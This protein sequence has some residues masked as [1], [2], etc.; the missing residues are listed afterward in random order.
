MRASLVI[1][2]LLLVP[3]KA[4]PA[5]ADYASLIPALQAHEARLLTIGWRLARGNAALC[6]SSQPA[7][8]A[9]LTDIRDFNRPGDAQAAMRLKGN[10][11]VA[12][13]ATGS[14]AQAAGLRAGEELIA[15]DGMAI[16]AKLQAYARIEEG[17]A[18]RGTVSL[19]VA[20]PGAAARNVAIRGEAACKV[21]FELLAG[22]KIAKS[23]ATGVQVG[24]ELLAEHPSDDVAATMVA[25]EMAHVLLV[26]L[27]RLDAGTRNYVTIRRTEREADGLA[28]W[29]M[30]NAGYDPAAAPRFMAAWGPRHSGGAMRRPNHDSWQDREALMRAQVA[31][32]AAARL[33]RPR[34]PLDWRN[35]FPGQDGRPAR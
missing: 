25:H 29:L 1:A 7:I 21:R 11:A 5:Q 6:R 19:T 28:P 35:D 14:P 10:V 18:R 8:G 26:H 30:A 12:A 4:F 34:S 24:V 22:S 17:L 31:R 20:A 27:A 13:V 33:A 2:L 16:S 23:D 15:V 32:I 3:A 9:M